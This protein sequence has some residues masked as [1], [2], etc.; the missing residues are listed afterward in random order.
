[1]QKIPDEG[2]IKFQCDWHQSLPF[3]TLE[4]AALNSWRQKLYTANLVGAY[5]D[6][7]GFGNVSQ[8]IEGNQFY[9]SGSKTGNFK[10]LDHT[11]YSKVIDFDITKN[12]VA[13]EGPAIASSESMSH[14]VIYEQVPEVNAVFHIHHLG[15]WQ[16]VLYK[17][18]TTEATAEYGSPEMAN[19]IVRL[20][21]E[22]DVLNQKVFAMAGHR[23]GLF[24]FGKTLEEAGTTILDLLAKN[25]PA[26]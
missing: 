3:N 12:W 22:T 24:S 6:G 16:K 25:I 18:P 13:C 23:E 5:P 1:M 19:E 17:I 26:D 11:H 8:R 2:Y 15:L 7:I 4:I 10:I 14:A 9:I 20:L 21:T